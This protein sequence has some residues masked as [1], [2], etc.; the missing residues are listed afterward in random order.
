MENQNLNQQPVEQPIPQP[1]VPIQ[2][3]Q[4]TITPQQPK[5]NW[6]VLILV[7]VLAIVSYTGVAYWQGMWPFSPSEEAM[8]EESTSLKKYES[9]EFGISLKY[10]SDWEVTQDNNVGVILTDSSGEYFSV[11]YVNPNTP[12]GVED[13]ISTKEILVDGRTVVKSIINTITPGVSNTVVVV[14]LEEVMLVITGFD[15]NN[16]DQIISSF[17]LSNGSTTEWKTYRN[18]EYGFE[19]KLSQ[20]WDG[21]KTNVRQLTNGGISVGFDIPY[22]DKYYIDALQIILYPSNIWPTIIWNTDGS[23]KPKLGENNNY[24]YT[25]ARGTDMGHAKLMM[26]SKDTIKILSTFKFT[27]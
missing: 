15:G 2:P 23:K 26:A 1:Q 11:Q 5:T 21:Y 8:V 12:I 14:E 20:N 22:A 16:F 10:P 7:L 24:V 4:P 9:Q 13:I 6:P 25:Y 17:K 19:I 18:E 27:N 3:E